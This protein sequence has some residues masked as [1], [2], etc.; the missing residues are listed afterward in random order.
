MSHEGRRKTFIPATA[1][2]VTISIIESRD[3]DRD[4]YVEGVLV[5]ETPDFYLLRLEHD[6]Y[7]TPFPKFT[8]AGV[9]AYR[10]HSS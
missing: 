5:G 1:P 3:P 7:P 10:M 4:Y 2:M 9:P 6:A 8:R